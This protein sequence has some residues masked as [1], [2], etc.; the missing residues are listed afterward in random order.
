[1]SGMIESLFWAGFA[2]VA[3]AYL[4][5]PCIVWV[6]TKLTKRLPAGAPFTGSV[7]IVLAAHNEAH[8]IRRRLDELLGLLDASGREGEVI[9]VSDGSTDD[10]VALARTCTS[11]RLRVEELTQNL[12]KAAALSHG[13]A[14]ARGDVLVFADARQRWAPEALQALLGNFSRPEIGGV[15]GELTLESDAG[16]MAGVGLYWRYEKWLRH[17]EGLLHSTVGVSGSICA[18]R[19]ELFTPIPAGTLLDDV[20]WPLCVAMK[21]YR[22][23]HDD[24]AIA[25]D[26]L[27]PEAVDEFRRKVRTLSGNFQLVQLLP[28]ALLPWRNP[29]WW[30]FVSHKLL[31]LVVPWAL[32]VMLFTSALLPQPFYRFAFWAQ[33]AGY[34]LAGLSVLLGKRVKLGVASAAA[35]FL[36]LNAAAWVAFW[37]WLS[38]SAGKSW[39]KVSYDP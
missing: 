24:T 2:A 1:M 7:S 30:Q 28:A 35:S 32:L 6:F 12:G 9:V 37:V 20:Y 18:V 10:T 15:S 27:P 36:V 25:Y 13:C 19:R 34:A 26:K 23:V 29:I 17:N 21:G 16:A 4:I 31:R 11:P 14:V 33:M 8:S 22:V 5:Y 38:G 39:R 3:Y